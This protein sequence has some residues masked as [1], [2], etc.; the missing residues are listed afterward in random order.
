MLLNDLGEWIDN[1]ECVVI[2]CLIIINDI[3]W[4]SGIMW[5]IVSSVMKKLV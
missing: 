4:M 5:E 3:V 1:R 2:I